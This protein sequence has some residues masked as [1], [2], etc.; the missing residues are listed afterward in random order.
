[1]GVGPVPPDTVIPDPANT[2]VISPVVGVVH[3]TIPPDTVNTCP[4]VPIPNLSNVL[5]AEA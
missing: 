1:M 5:P 2:S 4:A 3:D